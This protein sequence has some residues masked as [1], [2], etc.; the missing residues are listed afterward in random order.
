MGLL[1][2]DEGGISKGKLG[3]ILAASAG[4]IVA[5][6]AYFNV[7]LDQQTVFGIIVALLGLMGYGIRDAQK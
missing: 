1:T 7:P 4:L 5:V 6:S 2:R 3:A